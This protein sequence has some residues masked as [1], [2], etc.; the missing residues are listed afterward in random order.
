MKKQNKWYKSQYRGKKTPT[1]S[2]GSKGEQQIRQILRA[3]RIPHQEQY[4]FDGLKDQKPL[5]YDFA[6]MFQQQVVCLIEY[7]GEQHF[8]PVAHFG[9]MDGYVLR[10]RHD[11][12]KAN[13][14]RTHGIKLFYIRYDQ[15]VVAAMDEILD[16]YSITKWLAY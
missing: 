7:Q 9:G 16:W 10:R 6:L 8:K 14:C 2:T 3:K 5:R 1:Q 4:T 11:A 15:D 12:M 13:Y